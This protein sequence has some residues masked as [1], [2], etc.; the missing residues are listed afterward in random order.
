VDTVPGRGRLAGYRQALE[1]AAI[2]YDEDLVCFGNFRADC[3]P[4]MIECLFA[5]DREPPTAIFAANDVMAIAVI[6]ELMRRG[7]H[8][9]EDVA[10]CGYDDVPEAGKMV[11]ALTTISQKTQI[12]GRMLAQLI[13]ERLGS[14]SQLVE[15]KVP[16]EFEFV[17][18][19]ST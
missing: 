11:P 16:F 8:V 12:Q 7:L 15:R 6:Y 17:L 10:V 14:D 18:R 5:G 19:D 4:E 3:V 2:P 1:A 9:P 13:L